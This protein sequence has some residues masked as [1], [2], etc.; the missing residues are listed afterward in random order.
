[1]TIF[2]QVVKSLAVSRLQPRPCSASV[3]SAMLAHSSSSLHALRSSLLVL[4]PPFLS[5]LL[6]V[7]PSL[8]HSSRHHH[9]ITAE[10]KLSSIH[11]P[12]LC[13][14]AW[15]PKLLPHKACYTLPFPIISYR[16]VHGGG[17]TALL[18]QLC[19]D[20]PGH[21]EFPIALQDPPDPKLP[22]QQGSQNDTL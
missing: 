22:V 9:G 4:L 14:P 11:P 12:L 20:L 19:L 13:L 10:Q 3:A 1:M 7:S 17:S 16:P 5:S 8:P 6:S 15:E 18:G 21:L 2:S